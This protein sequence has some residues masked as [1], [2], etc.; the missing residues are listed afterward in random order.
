M[1]GDPYVFRVPREAAGAFVLAALA[2]V[3]AGLIYTV[4]PRQAAKRDISLAGGMTVSVVAVTGTAEKE[5]V[6]AKAYHNVL[7]Q[8]E[9]RARAEGIRMFSIGVSDEWSVERGIAKLRSIGRFDEVVVGR[10]W[11]NSGIARFVAV[12]TIR[13]AVPQVVVVCQGVVTDSIPFV[14]DEPSTVVRL[15]GEEELANA[16]HM[17]WGD[18]LCH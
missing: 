17:N 15:V 6:L 2:V 9:R 18:K 16:R 1:T 14:Y 3:G 13:A 5:P 7:N 10:N 4:Y 11:F 12:P 8:V